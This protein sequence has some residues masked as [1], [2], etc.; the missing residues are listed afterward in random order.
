MKALKG[1]RANQQIARLVF[2]ALGQGAQHIVFTPLAR[3]TAQLQGRVAMGKS[4]ANK[5]LLAHIVQKPRQTVV[6]L[7]DAIDLID[8]KTAP[9]QRQH[10]AKR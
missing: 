10:L 7:A 3:V 1:G 9:G 5:A 4:A 2:T 8:P 6:L